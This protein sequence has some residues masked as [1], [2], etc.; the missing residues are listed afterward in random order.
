MLK[1]KKNRKGL[2]MKVIII[3]ILTALAIGV[4]AKVTLDSLAS[5]S[6][7]SQ[8]NACRASNVAKD[9]L[10]DETKLLSSPRLCTTI[11]K[12]EKK[13]QVP[14]KNYIQEYKDEKIAAEA[15]LRD[16]IMNCHWEWLGDKEQDVFKDYPWETTCFVCYTFKI[17][18]DVEDV[19]FESLEESLFDP[20]Y[21]EDTSDQC[22]SSGETI[23]GGFWKTKE[24]CSDW[25]GKF[26]STKK[27]APDSDSKCCVKKDPTNECENKGGECFK[28]ED[29]DNDDKC[30]EEPPEDMGLYPKWMCPKKTESCYVKEDDQYSYSRYIRE[31]GSVPGDIVFMRA[32][33]EETDK[34]AYIG[35][36]EYAVTFLSP[37]EQ[38]CSGEGGGAEECF[39]TFGS[40]G[41]GIAG[42]VAI[43]KGPGVLARARPVI[44]NVVKKVVG[45]GGRFLSRAILPISLAMTALEMAGLDP[46]DR[47]AKLTTN[48]LAK[49]ITGS[50]PNMVVV[51]T[52]DRAREMQCTEYYGE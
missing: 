15:E 19:T 12:R 18:D 9:W 27:I 38:F 33:S 13:K 8:V 47:L 4:I 1:L 41:I 16:M 46:F 21:A 49:P 20:Y 10:E 40:I 32:G 48:F 11:D 50:V 17:K 30:E 45:V 25:D 35:G 36:R 31:G 26:V 7:Q 28:C 44:V 3:F 52:L 2:A 23:I 24:E 5:T 14:T 34:E 22:A 51:S 37:N 6:E 43:A 39:A 42:A 29:K